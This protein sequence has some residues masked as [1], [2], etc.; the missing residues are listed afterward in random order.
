MTTRN[1][2]RG[3]LC[4][5]VVIFYQLTGIS[6]Q[7][8][9]LINDSIFSKVLNEERSMR[10]ILP[11]TYKPGSSERYEVIYLT[12]GEWVSELF[13]FIYRFAKGENYVP[14]II[15]VAVP[16]TYI[17]KANQRDRDFLPVHVDN[18]PISGGADKFI[19]FLKDELIP[20]IDKNY[21]TN[22]TN[23][24]YGHSYGG[25]FVMYTLLT[26][27][28]LF[29]TYYSTDPPMGWNNDFVIRL[30]SEKLEKLPPDKILWIAGIT[31]TH[32]GMGI[33]R[34]DSV[35]KLKAPPGLHWKVLTF[36]N[37]KHNS[38]R[39][40]AM[41]DGIKFSYSGYSGEPLVFHPMNGI[42][43]KDKPAP[44]FITTTFPEMRYTLDGS[45]PD[46]TSPKADPMMQITGPAQLVIK[47]F[48]T[49]GKYDHVAKGS[50]PLGEV[51]PASQK[52][53]KAS[54]GGLK[55]T[56][57]EGSWDKMPD[58]NK[59]KPLKTGIADSLFSFSNL[60]LK[61]N[62]GCS[63]EGYIEIEE[64]G[65]YLFATVTKNGSRLYLGDKLIIDEDGVHPTE[66]A[67][68]F[69]IPLEKGFYPVRLEYF[70]KDADPDLQ[71]VYMKPGTNNP[72]P[73]PPANLYH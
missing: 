66:K 5:I 48:S 4:L 26:Q 35:L 64:D 45:E 39:L 65:Y 1:I 67:G 15:I 24:L 47:S 68:S 58:F 56:L 30:A 62:F 34:M 42:L 46:M 3:T 73:I 33:G 7:D 32:E 71:F 6:A 72:S 23:S 53:R 54:N 14:P 9:P 55:Y 50:F 59:L 36:P 61:T 17:N 37:E 51:L 31:E 43:L 2:L 16:N 38:V 21:P 41:Y 40:K 70:Q 13:P 29:Q 52:P 27:P 60:P 19:A 44:V 11:D 8:N 20:Y 18:P 10:I 12:D 25:L 69:L 63:F 28:Q 22:G 57:F 49:S